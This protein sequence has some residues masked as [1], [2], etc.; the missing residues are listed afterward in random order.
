MEDEAIVNSIFS[1][2]NQIMHAD[3]ENGI[4]TKKGSLIYIL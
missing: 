1:P 4:Q 3:C 2:T